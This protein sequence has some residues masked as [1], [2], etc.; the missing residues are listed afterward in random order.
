[1]KFFISTI[2][3]LMMSASLVWADGSSSELPASLGKTMKAMSAN[4]KTITSQATDAQSNQNSAIL[5]DEFVALTLHAKDFTPDTI[6]EAPAD[7][8][9]ELQAHYKKMLD[10]TA[11]LGRQLAAAF[12]AGD[13]TKAAALLNQLVT[14]KKSGHSEFK[15]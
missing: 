4:L 5:A 12:R 2:T 10:E 14:A 1:M 11:E 8:Q 3:V 13:N 7:Q 15:N 6:Q 9:P